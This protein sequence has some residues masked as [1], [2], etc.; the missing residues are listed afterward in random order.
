MTQGAAPVTCPRCGE[1]LPTDAA[2]CS[3]CG[4]P[5]RNQPQVPESKQQ[6]AAPVDI[7]R[8]D[9][10]P[11]LTGCALSVIIVLGL[12]IIIAVAVAI[13]G[14]DD[15]ALTAPLPGSWADRMCDTN[16]TGPDTVSRGGKRYD[17]ECLKRFSWTDQAD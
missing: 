6:V 4:A 5:Q 2:F 11:G 15:Q 7:P 12:C 17:E 16:E 10:K 13:F 14:G 1:E 3:R 8:P 9:T